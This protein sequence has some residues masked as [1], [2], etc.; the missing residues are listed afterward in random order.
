MDSIFKTNRAH[1]AQIIILQHK[2][3][4]KSELKNVLTHSWF[5]FRTYARLVQRLR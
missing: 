4:K 1:K 3:K 5:H 2:N